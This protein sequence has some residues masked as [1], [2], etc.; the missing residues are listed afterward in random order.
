MATESLALSSIRHSVARTVNDLLVL[1]VATSGSTTTLADTNNIL[2]SVTNSLQGAWIYRYAGTGSGAERGVDSS[3]SN[4]VTI[5][6][7]TWTAPDTTSYYEIH[8]RW[9]V[10]DYNDA[11]NAGIRAL[12]R[13][14]MSKKRD[15]SLLTNCNILNPLFTNWTSATAPTS[16]TNSGANLTQNVVRLGNIAGKTLLEYQAVVYSTSTKF[17]LQATD[18]TTTVSD[19]HDGTG[20]NL[21]RVQLTA[22]AAASSV[23]VRINHTTAS[24]LT[25]AQETGNRLYGPYSCKVTENGGEIAYV[26]RMYAPDYVTQYDYTLPS[27]FASVHSVELEASSPSDGEPS[28]TFGFYPLASWEWEAGQGNVAPEP[29]IR[30][31]PDR[32]TPSSNRMISIAGMKYPDILSADAD[33]ADV[34]PEL[35]RLYAA[36]YLYA[37]LG[38]PLAAFFKSQFERMEA[39]A[40]MPYPAGSR[41]VEAH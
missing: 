25:L 9:R 3:S 24:S 11:I 8:R 20:W 34:N 22:A 40:P 1:G 31:R 37:S 21:L 26:A 17:R 18:G 12:R 13:N 23:A 6:G 32:F 36:Y 27:G 19:A 33:T 30:F 2:S 5:A 29:Y 28:A 35:L 38:D 16:W 41:L 14:F 10:A 4:S 15:V 7:S 39:L